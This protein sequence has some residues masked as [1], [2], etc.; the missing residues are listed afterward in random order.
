MRYCLGLLLFCA[1][2]AYG[3]A[4]FNGT[5]LRIAI[6]GNEP[7]IYQ[8][9]LSTSGQKYQ[10]LFPDLFM[11]LGDLLDFKPEFIFWSNTDVPFHEAVADGSIDV[12]IGDIV[13]KNLQDTYSVNTYIPAD[14]T[15]LGKSDMNDNDFFAFLRPFSAGV[16]LIIICLTPVLA[17]VFWFVE[18]ENNEAFSDKV[19]D[20]YRDLFYIAFEMTFLS[21]QM[22]KRPRSLIGRI[23]AFLWK[24]GAILIMWN[25]FSVLV[26]NVSRAGEGS[27]TIM[28]F[29]RSRVGV[30]RK[31]TVY[32]F[33]ESNDFRF[34]EVFS[35]YNEAVSELLN[36]KI[37]VFVGDY[38]SL[39]V[40]DVK[41]DDVNI[42]S[43][44]FLHEYYGLVIPHNETLRKVWVDGLYMAQAGNLVETIY[45]RW[46]RVENLH[47][48]STPSFTTYYPRHVAGI[49]VFFFGFPIFF[50]FFARWGVNLFADLRRSQKQQ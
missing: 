11:I 12:A 39:L 20:E 47:Y 17:I 32:T 25:Y 14:V 23:V 7:Y 10:G 8:G 38:L 4:F 22:I 34:V 40:T 24:F 31:S 29:Q 46:L 19:L 36:D 2:F 44:P 13:A 9:V 6:A 5:T 16:W 49:L 15:I 1:L 41:Y 18:Y 30:I 3:Q 27:R 43:K 45:N 33:L 28:D 37:D 26:F 50:G 42:I 48:P 35:D 21:G